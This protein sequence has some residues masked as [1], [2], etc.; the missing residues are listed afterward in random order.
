MKVARIIAGI[1]LGQD[2]EKVLAYASFFARGFRADLHLLHVI[3]Y[4]VTPPSYLSPYMEEEKKAAE[5]KFM[6]WKKRLEN[7]AV[8]AALEVVTGRLRESFD[9]IAR[10]EK[11]D[12]L[13]LGFR[14]H[15]FRRSSSESLIKG[16]ELPM[17]VVRGQKAD[18]AGIGSVKIRRLLCPTDFSG[19]SRKALDAAKEL[20]DIFSA[21]MEV[22]HVLPGHII[23]KM[24]AR[25]HKDRAMEELSRQA[26]EGLKTVLSEAGIEKEG[27]VI[28]G[29]PH[30]KISAFS[31][32]N[33]ID[34]VVIGARGLSFIRGML[35]GSVTDSVLKSSPCPVLVVH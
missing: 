35:I 13:V 22:L 14:S 32:D 4:L 10:R 5:E 25:E 2:T 17:L 21:D 31:L 7:G 1:D 28:E 8:S 24:E 26:A 23:K 20:K 11:A 27:I 29:E 9:S 6:Q 3:D 12:M 34:L 30:K 16:L 15:T 19:S 33:D 18:A